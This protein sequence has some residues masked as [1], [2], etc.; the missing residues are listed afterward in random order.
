[1]ALT[2]MLAAY[3]E[4]SEVRE[5]KR[6]TERE[7]GVDRQIHREEGRERARDRQTNRQTDG[8]G[9]RAGGGERERE[10]MAPTTM[11]AAY[12]ESSEVTP[13]LP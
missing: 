4:S 9:R 10:S 3:Q 5:T 12:Q 6:Q 13:S 2:T 7:G 1:M 11:L 8:E